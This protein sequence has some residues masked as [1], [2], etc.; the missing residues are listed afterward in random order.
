MN[1]FKKIG[2][3]ML[4]LVMVLTT[5][6]ISVPMASL[7][8]EAISGA[9]APTNMNY[10]ALGID[11][12]AW[13]AG[14]GSNT[15]LVD[16]N[17]LKNSGCQFVILRISYGQSLD[18]AFVSFYNK[19]RAAGMPMGVYMYGLSTTRDGA[20]SDAKWVISVI[21]KYNMY[22]EYP[23]YYDIEEQKQINLSASAK[24]ALCEGW[25]DTLYAAGYFPG[26]YA[27]KS[28]IMSSLSSSFK[29]KYDLWIPHVKSVDEYAA[30]YTPYSIAYNQQGFS[31][32]QYS[33]SNIKNGSYIYKGVY[34]SGTTPVY[35]LDLDVCYKDYP[36]IMKTYGYNNC[37]S[38]EKGN[39]Q[40]VIDEAKHARYS[41]YSQSGLDNLRSAYDSAVAVYNSA[42][43]KEAD[44]KNARTNL[45]N[46]I[47]GS[48]SSALSKGKSY[49]ATDSGR[50]DIYKDDN[51]RLT[52]GVKGYIDPGTEKYSGFNG[53]TEIVVDLGATKSSNLYT[54]YMAAGEWGIA[55]P[56]EEQL[57]VEILASDSAT[58]GFTSVGSTGKMVKTNVNGNWNLMTVSLNSETV[59]N[60]RYIKFKITNTAANGFIWLDEVEVSAG[61][62][63]LSGGVY[64]NGINEK[65]GAGDCHIFTSSFGTIT[66]ESANHNWTGNLIAKWDSEKNAYVVKS[67]EGGNGAAPNL[68]L[69]SDEI[70]IAAHNW[71]SG[72]TDGSAV[73]GSAAN[74]AAVFAAKPGDLVELSGINVS[75]GKMS[76]AS[77]IKITTEKVSEEVPPQEEPHVHTPGPIDCENGQICLSCNVILQA[78]EGHDEGQWY[79]DDEGIQELRCTKCGTVLD[80]K[81]SV[82]EVGLRGDIDGNGIIE[83]MDY[84]LLKRKYFGTYQFDEDQMLKGD[85]D[86]SYEID[87]MDYVLLRRVYFGAFTFKE[88]IVYK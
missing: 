48:G 10:Y 19:G 66:V 54:V 72:I 24:N 12:S 11:I 76:A 85:V 17:A 60:K 37:G 15:A 6:V 55:I 69:A 59:V 51:I 42:S 79:E 52:D 68:T 44:Y 33:W 53:S 75:T 39:L 62:A 70:L 77:Y 82:T 43:S 61:N 36:T 27:G 88:P 47:K 2:A 29:A 63:K 49:T 41:N 7:E 50:T 40:K 20:I 14:G 73:A 87:S 57:T 9:G 74:S 23:I 3:F 28:Q 13:Q 45:E 34:R 26:I 1:M 25:C 78:A 46:A 81:L 8:A 67:V 64:V 18:K 31:M 21:E 58:S 38:D 80:T 4:M 71:E 5:V 30:Q 32:W 35:A 84:V 56:T 83:S 22:F 16:F 65:V 86:D